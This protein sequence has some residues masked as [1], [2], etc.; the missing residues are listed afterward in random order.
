M[1]VAAIA[2]LHWLI[3]EAAGL[4]AGAPVIMLVIVEVHV[5]VLAPPLPA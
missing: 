3:V 5:T 4:L 1:V 2:G